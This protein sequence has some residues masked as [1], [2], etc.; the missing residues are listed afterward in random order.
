MELMSVLRGNFSS[1]RF[2]KVFTEVAIKKKVLQCCILETIDFLLH[3]IASLKNALQTKIV[4]TMF[5]MKWNYKDKFIHEIIFP[6]NYIAH[7]V[8]NITAEMSKMSKKVNNIVNALQSYNNKLNG[9][10][11]A[12]IMHNIY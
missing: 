7:W 8:N 3:S 10:I 12:N 9:N 6:I 11:D 4:F 2:K 1:I 5:M